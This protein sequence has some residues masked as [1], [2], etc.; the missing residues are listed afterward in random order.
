M[1]VCLVSS[2]RVADGPQLVL[3]II[4]SSFLFLFCFFVHDPL[5]FFFFLVC[6][7]VRL[8][9]CFVL[10]PC[11][12]SF[13]FLFFV[14]PPPPP[15]LPSSSSTTTTTSSPPLPPPPSP[16]SLHDWLRQTVGPEVSSVISFPRLEISVPVGWALNTNN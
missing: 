6:L 7:C 12:F 8:F 5:I 2:R 4:H 15:P 13:S 16:F 10:F 1:C 3:S 14:D 9:V 11:L